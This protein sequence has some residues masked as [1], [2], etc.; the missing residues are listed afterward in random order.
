MPL[1]PELEEA[2]DPS[3]ARRRQAV[4]VKG[5]KKVNLPHLGAWN[6]DAC[7]RHQDGQGP[8][9]DCQFQA[10]GGPFFDHQTTTIT[11]LYLNGYGMVA[12]VPGAGKTNSALGLVAL[13]KERGELTGRAIIVCQTP[14]VLQWFSEAQRFVPGIATE[15]VYAG[16]ARGERINRYVRNWDLLIIGYH[17]LL[18]D[19]EMLR[20]LEPML[21][22]TDDV[23]PLLNH[24]NQTHKAIA[25]LAQQAERVVVM[26][27][28]NLQTR[29]QQIHAAMVPIGAREIWGTLG[30]FERR[31]IRS[32]SV[33]VRVPARKTAS[34]KRA[35]PARQITVQKVTGYKNMAE[36]G[37]KLR[38]WVIRHGYEDLTDIRMPEIMPPE[39]V[40]LEMGKEQRVKYEE[41]REGV[42]K[43][44]TEQGTEVKAVTALTMIGYGQQICA[45]IPALVGGEIDGPSVKLDWLM[46]R[47]D[48]GVWEDQ[49][50]VCFIKNLG[51]VKAFE[52]RLA[53]AG[54]GFATVSGHEPDPVK[55]RAAQKK[56]WEDPECRVFMGT[57]AIE[58][59]LNLQVAGIVVNVDTH[60]NPERMRQI[61]GR[62]RRA[63][64]AHSHVFVFT[65]F[66]TDSQEEGY[67]NVLKRRAA[68]VDYVWDEE[69]EMYEALTPMELLQL[70]RPGNR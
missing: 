24:A 18:R 50:I 49:K 68:L 54:I 27:A 32:E 26:N 52:K 69:G 1:P 56:F 37:E 64:S 47:L 2:L 43:L 53:K 48:G 12:S 31:Y 14:A 9:I 42:L 39:T 16:M 29:L 59:S 21:L 17:M 66:C 22:I 46:D 6:Y 4:R 38:P 3:L 33:Y 67:M 7:A 45:G 51:L 61:L 57:A 13:L 65:L 28:S 30:S 62:V 11:Y 25:E 63:G 41:L 10:C 58:R 60:L 34:G 36:F 19:R 55:R 70:I 44:K 40:W 20:Q 23:D 5:L 8:R 15:V 35:G